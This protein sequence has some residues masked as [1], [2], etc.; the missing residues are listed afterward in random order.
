MEK[1]KIKPK[2]QTN[3]EKCPK[4]PFLTVGIK[5]SHGNNIQATSIPEFSLR[6]STIIQSQ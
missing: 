5:D 2:Q 6:K 1:N 3:K 4:I